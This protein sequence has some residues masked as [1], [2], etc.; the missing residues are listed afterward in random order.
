[1]PAA[2]RELVYAAD[3]TAHERGVAQNPQ[4]FATEDAACQFVL[5][6]LATRLSQ[7]VRLTPGQAAGIAWPSR[8]SR[9]STASSMPQEARR[10][11]APGVTN[12]LTTTV[13]LVPPGLTERCTCIFPG[14]F[15]VTLTVVVA[16]AASVPDIGET[17]TFLVRPG[18][19]LIVQLTGP[20]EAVSVIVPS[21]GGIC[22][23]L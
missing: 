6:L 16:S 4:T 13:T 22:Q 19:S 14:P 10:Q 7:A 1:V 12:Y 2:T 20:P 3:V 9:S 15:T 11:P 23:P 21:A 18:G 17:M 8:A 5:G